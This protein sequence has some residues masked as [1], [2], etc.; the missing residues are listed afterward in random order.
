M[1][2]WSCKFGFDESETTGEGG[3]FCYYNWEW[4]DS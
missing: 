4:S 3:M 2:A 1:K